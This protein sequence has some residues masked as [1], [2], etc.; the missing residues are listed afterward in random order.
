MALSASSRG[1]LEIS[2]HILRIW[3]EGLIEVEDGSHFSRLLLEMDADRRS[4][5]LF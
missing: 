3:S 1:I 2:V 4:M 5:G